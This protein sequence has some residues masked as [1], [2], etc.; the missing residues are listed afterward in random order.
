MHWL[1]VLPVGL[2][3]TMGAASFA[4]FVVLAV[5][6]GEPVQ[7]DRRVLSLMIR[8]SVARS[9][10]FVLRPL[11]L[12]DTGP[13]IDVRTEVPKTTPVL[14]VPGASNNRSSLGFMRSFLVFRGFP[15]VWAVNPPQLRDMG[16]ADAAAELGR[17]IERL[18]AEAKS[19]QVDLVG[20]GSGG[21]VA[22]WYARHLDTEGRVRRLVTVGTPWRGSKMSVFRRGR[23]AEETRYG[24]HVL[25]DLVPQTRTISIWSPD[26]PTVIPTSS[27][28]PDHGV[29]S[30]QVES[31]GHH[32]MLMSARVFRAVQAALS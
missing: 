28:V 19:E 12:T 24:A 29:E 31:A 18:R 2:L 5:E 17:S 22:A 15:W 1:L 13:V 20:H 6:R 26:D 4:G 30:V 11:G 32:E 7:L 25:D 21:L 16:L 23:L 27:A 10:F 9:L 14:L 3:V 8:E